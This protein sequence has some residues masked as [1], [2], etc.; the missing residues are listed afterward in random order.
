MNRAT[1]TAASFSQRGGGGG[2]D[3]HLIPPSVPLIPCWYPARRC[4]QLFGV[5]MIPHF[6]GVALIV[7]AVY[8]TQ[9]QDGALASMPRPP[10]ASFMK[11]SGAGRA[12]ADPG[13]HARWLVHTD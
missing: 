3:R 8:V 11:P 1:T 10:L 13:R 9:A 4:R 2:G 7:P 5:G 6:D 12:G